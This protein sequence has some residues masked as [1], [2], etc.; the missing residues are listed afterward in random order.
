[1]APEIV[2]FQPDV[3]NDNQRSLTEPSPSQSLEDESKGC[4]SHHLATKHI[5][6]QVCFP[7]LLST[8]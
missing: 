5:D 4:V 7:A 3:G 6:T 2:V 8:V 1:M